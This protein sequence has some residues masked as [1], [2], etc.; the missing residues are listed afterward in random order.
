MCGYL[1]E[2]D[3][4]QLVNV[5]GNIGCRYLLWLIIYHEVVGLKF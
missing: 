3:D 4:M 2:N 5:G 1:G